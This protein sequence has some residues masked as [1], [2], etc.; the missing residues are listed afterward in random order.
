LGFH[1]WVLLGSTF[2]LS[3]LWAAVLLLLVRLRD[4]SD[5]TG[6]RR[7]HMAVELAW[8]VIPAILVL[9]VV[10]PTLQ[11]RSAG[12]GGRDVQVAEATVS[13]ATP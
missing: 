13:T 9:S 2:V 11:A 10:I 4:E 3:A 1:T 7:G 8:A 6:A 5:G 12:S